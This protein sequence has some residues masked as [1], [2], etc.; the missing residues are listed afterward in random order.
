MN[1]D[2]SLK[3]IDYIGS[4]YTLLEWITTNILKSTGWNSLNGKRIADLFSGSGIVSYY[5][6]NKGAITISNDAE[7]YSSILTSA[8]SISCYNENVKNFIEETNNDI[9]NGLHN[10]IPYGF[11]TRNYSKSS[12]ESHRMFF[13]VENAKRIDYIR[14]KIENNIFDVNDKNFLLASLIV[15]SNNV[16]NVAAVFA[17]Y[18]KNW[19]KRATL[20]LIF[21]PIHTKTILPHIESRVFCEDVHDLDNI[22]SDAIYIDPPY[23][24]RVYSKNYFLFNLISMRPVEQERRTLSGKTGIPDNCFVSEFSSKVKAKNSFIRLINNIYRNTNYIFLSYNTESILTKQ[25]MIDIL[26]PY[27]NVEIIERDYKRFKSS[28]A[29]QDKEIKEL[30][31]CLK[32]THQD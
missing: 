8:Y 21:T 18:L 32:I 3:R 24:T 27:G 20:P 29:N 7:L 26:E 19:K 25:E 12:E 16:G 13:S 1:T 31:F 6:R 9:N 10:N 17:C 2:K 23:N 4:K 14:Q 15:S 11:I 5:L 30:L 28:N 22:T